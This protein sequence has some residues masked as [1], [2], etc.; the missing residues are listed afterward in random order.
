MA[1][2][3]KKEELIWR[4]KKRKHYS[5]NWDSLKIKSSYFMTMIE[6]LLIVSLIIERM[7]MLLKMDSLINIP[8]MIES[9]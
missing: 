3:H 2:N 8:Y 4:K 7:K 6:K 5:E 1:Y 9:L